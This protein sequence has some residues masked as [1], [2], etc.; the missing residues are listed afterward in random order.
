MK[1][2]Q[3]T[4]CFS[5]AHFQVKRAALKPS[6]PSLHLGQNNGFQHPHGKPACN[7]IHT[8]SLYIHT[9]T[10]PDEKDHLYSFTSNRQRAVCFQV[11][12]KL[13]SQ[14]RLVI[15]VD[16]LCMLHND[17]LIL[18]GGGGGYW[19]FGW[20]QFY[21]LNPFLPLNQI[22]VRTVLSLPRPCVPSIRLSKSCPA[23]TQK[24]YMS[25]VSYFQG[26]ST[27]HGTCAL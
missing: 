9:Q 27:F 5:L 25:T 10:L 18:E 2:Y 12:M 17:Q 11:I 26:R 20:T 19:C 14:I 13:A 21:F 16:S 1:L 15:N 23:S 4:K 8:T 6:Y 22:L 24:L 7:S 3:I